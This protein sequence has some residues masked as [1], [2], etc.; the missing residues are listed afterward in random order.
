MLLYTFIQYYVQLIL[1]TSVFRKKYFLDPHTSSSVNTDLF[2]SFYYPISNTQVLYQPNE[3]IHAIFLVKDLLF[4]WKNVSKILN[5]L[6]LVNLFTSASWRNW[7]ILN[8]AYLLLMWLSNNPLYF[9]FSLCN[10]LCDFSYLICYQKRKLSKLC[11][12][13]VILKHNV[14]NT[15]II[16]LLFSRP[17]FLWDCL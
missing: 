13:A 3:P 9:I 12:T 17:C 5:Y 15:D 16:I 6:L 1:A 11:K 8:H 7:W 10:F 4:Q 2:Y 14:N